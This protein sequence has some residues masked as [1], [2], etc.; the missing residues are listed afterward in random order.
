M[1]ARVLAAVAVTLVATSALAQVAPKAPREAQRPVPNEPP[2]WTSLERFSSDA[3]FLRYVR[4]IQSMHGRRG[5]YGALED[6]VALAEAQPN[7]P[8]PPPPPPPSA[9]P[10]VGAV[11][12][13]AAQRADS[14][15]ASS[16]E[17]SSITNTQTQGVDEGGIVKQIGRYLIILQD[18]RLFVADTRA[19][20]GGGLALANRTNVYRYAGQDTWYDELLTS[21]NR[22]LVTGYSYRERASEVTVLRLADNGEL[23]RE[24][25]YYISSNDYYDVENYATRLVN[26]NLVIYTP[27]AVTGVNANRAVSWPLIRRWISDGERETRT[28]RGRPLFD[29]QDI[30]KPVQS[31]QNPV[32]HSVSVCP[33]G[34]DLSGD[35]LECRTTA[36]VGTGQREFFVSTSDIYLWT[37]PYPYEDNA[38]CAAD[39]DSA[40]PA[41]IFQVPLNG[42]SPR[43]LH[44]RGQPI[45]QLALDSSPTE[46]RALLSMNTSP[47]NRNTRSE[48][49]MAY[50]R[51]PFSALT[52]TPRQAPARSYTETPTPGS[53]TYEVRYTQTHVVYGSRDQY[54]SGPPQPGSGDTNQTGRVVA[55]PLAQPRNA[56]VIEAPHNIIR[57]ER[58]GNDAILTG[59]RSDEG[60]SVSLLDL[61][62]R[63]PRIA[64]TQILRNR[65]ES[66]GRSHAFNALV[67]PEGDGIMGLPTITRVKQGHRWAW[68][69]EA[70]DISFLTVNA[71]NQLGIAGELNADPNARDSSYQCEVSCVDW[72]GN[73]RALFIG[74]R[75][76][77]LS[78]TELIEGELVGG[79]IVERQRL[80]L[81]RRPQRVAA[82]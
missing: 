35:E 30:Y 9:A 15:A 29:A 54:R 48:A 18:G 81:S 17:P 70:S 78:A 5:Q 43:A 72:Y 52:T 76:F 41:T 27:L 68:R 46:F 82:R 31:T 75:V 65:Y 22:V 45:N 67:R 12:G 1:L 51:V 11:A 25:T 4:D 13:A 64:Q 28:T 56:T 60:L 47:C 7:A 66:E 40:L 53:M 80:N 37:T 39:A 61:G 73:T 8:P 77:G 63:T 36:F 19:N 6:S 2:V 3:E 16:G 57:V 74:N 20:G 50:F 49:E 44:A 79:R 34:G 55:V 38:R 23:T 69:S 14:G 32:V 24:A 58:A 59:Y 42:A 21:G 62:A 26:G 33:L 71:Q 10:T